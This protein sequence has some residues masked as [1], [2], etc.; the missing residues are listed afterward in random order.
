MRNLRTTQRLADFK[1]GGRFEMFGLEQKLGL[2]LDQ[3]R[4]DYRYANY[5]T[6]LTEYVPVDLFNFDPGAYPEPRIIGLDETQRGHFLTKRSSGT[7]SLTLSPWAPLKLIGVYRWIALEINA[8][9]DHRDAPSYLGLSYALNPRWNA[10]SSW[11]EVY[12]SNSGFADE[13]GRILAPT[14]GSHYETGLKYLSSDGELNASL[15]LYRIEEEGFRRLVRFEQGRFPFCCYDLGSNQ[16]VLS[17]GVELDIAGTLRAGWKVS[18]GYAYNRN[19]YEG[20]DSDFPGEPFNI[21]VPKHLFKL[22]STW[23]PQAAGW[24]PLSLGGGIQALDP[25]ASGPA[26]KVVQR[27][28]AVIDAHIGWQFNPRWSTTLNL[29]NVFDREYFLSKSTLGFGGNF[30]G[31]PRNFLLTLR[32]TYD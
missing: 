2:H 16:R 14:V 24:T 26:L 12:H 4:D 9:R 10:Y 3:A 27:G 17:E 20:S 30:H 13:R 22:W 23:Q 5:L 1:L 6:D 31:E 28:Y 18:M 32:G 15:A 29:N 25:A 7:V 8:M 19:S 21:R 11:A